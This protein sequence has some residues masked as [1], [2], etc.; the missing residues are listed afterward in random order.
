MVQLVGQQSIQDITL[1]LLIVCNTSFSDNFWNH[2]TSLDKWVNPE[3]FYFLCKSNFFK[4][5]P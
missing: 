3:I 5:V 1:S 4:K 2:G